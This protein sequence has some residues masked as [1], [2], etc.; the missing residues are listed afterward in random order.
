MK[1]SIRETATVLGKSERQVRYMIQQGGL[2]AVKHGSRWRIDADHLPLDEAQRRA[3]ARRI[4]SARQAF[5]KGLAPAEKAVGE[6]RKTYTLNNLVA[7]GT[8][9]EIYR[10]MLSSLGFGDVACGRLH[11]AL[12]L[13]SRGFHSFHPKEKA[14]CYCAARCAAATAVGELLLRAADGVEHGWA[15]RLE[16][17]LIPKIAGLVAANEKRSR[18]HRFGRRDEL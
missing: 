2:K 13:V 18:R 5:E 11:E 6:R 17:E 14:A 8:G 10:E 12:M 1:L 3:L 9:A 15:R 16:E 7:F 4:D